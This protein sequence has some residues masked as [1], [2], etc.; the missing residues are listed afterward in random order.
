MIFFFALD[1]GINFFIIHYML[2]RKWRVR[3]VM[4]SKLPSM[5]LFV[6]VF[7]SDTVHLSNEQMGM[8]IRLLFFAWNKNGEGIPDDAELINRVCLAN[9]EKEK[10]IS[11]NPSIALS[12][13]WP[14]FVVY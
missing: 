14:A 10:D 7:V 8:Y 12:I 4:M 6:D 13:Y 2:K 3:R 9:T 5:P 1:V 11:I